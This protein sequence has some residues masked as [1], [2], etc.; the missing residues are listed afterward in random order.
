MNAQPVSTTLY[1]SGDAVYNEYT[2]GVVGYQASGSIKSCT[3]RGS[4]I[5]SSNQQYLYMGGI[6]GDFAE[7]EAE[8]NVNVAKLDLQGDATSAVKGVRYASVG[9]LYG[10]FGAVQSDSDKNSSNS[11]PITVLNVETAADNSTTLNLGGVARLYRFRITVVVAHQ[12]GRRH[13]RSGSELHRVRHRRHRGFDRV[14]NLRL[15]KL[16]NPDDQ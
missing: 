14:R 3:N 9:G 7:G 1:R 13:S 4:M 12:Y 11:G 2:G 10:R 8:N 16:G 5:S 6:A 15:E